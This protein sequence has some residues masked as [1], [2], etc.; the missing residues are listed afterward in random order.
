[1]I[2]QSQSQYK[3]EKGFDFYLYSIK[4]AGRE[5]FAWIMSQ[6]SL[7]KK[8]I[9]V[10]IALDNHMAVNAIYAHVKD[11]FDWTDRQL[12]LYKSNI[13]LIVIH[14][15]NTNFEIYQRTLEA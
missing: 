9:H 14:H 4:Q 3:A 1:M 5:M 10:H 13:R 8:E 15:N 6:I 2:T 12:L 7:G 11:L